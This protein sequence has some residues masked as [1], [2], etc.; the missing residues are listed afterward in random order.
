MRGT[1]FFVGLVFAALPCAASDPAPVLWQSPGTITVRDWIW[2]PGGE[3]RAPRPPFEFVDEDRHGTNAKIGVRDAKG[4]EWVV[5]FGE[6]IHSD[7]FA[8]RLLFALGYITQ[9]SYFVA[10]G[11]ITGAHDLR[12]TKPF[13]AKDGSFFYARFK[14]RDRQMLAS[15]EGRTW[16]WDDNPFVGAPELNGLKILL[17]LTSNWDA[18]DARDGKGSNTSVFS[19]AGYGSQLY[20]AFDDWGATMGKWG[21]FFQRDKWDPAGFQ[22]QTRIFVKV[23]PDQTIEWGYRGKHGKDVTSGIRLDDVRWLLTYLSRVTDEELRAGLRASGA[24]DSAIETYTRSLRDRIAQLE[25]LT[26]S[27]VSP[28]PTGAASL[29]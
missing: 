23:A 10:S 1:C 19:K 7:V 11:V 22:E 29:R 16:S 20:Y 6:E 21:G 18:K 28:V 3:A 2:G 4:D 12:R 8:T 9:P 13:I 24:S 15:A 27:P 25:S 5:K 26:A 14:L 17:M